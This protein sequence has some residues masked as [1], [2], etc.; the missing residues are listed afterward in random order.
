MNK[1]QELDELKVNIGE[2]LHHI[3]N[4]KEAKKYGYR[5]FKEYCEDKLNIS[6]REANKLINISDYYLNQVKIS[7]SD[8]LDY[9]WDKLVVMYPM[10]NEMSIS[11]VYK[12][13]EGL[14]SLSLAH[15]NAE[16]RAYKEEQKLKKTKLTDIINELFIDHLCSSLN[17]SKSEV[18]LMLARALYFVD[19]EKL[20]KMLDDGA[21]IV[22]GIASSYEE[23]KEYTKKI[24]S[25]LRNSID[26]KLIE[27]SKEH[28]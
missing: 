27:L 16:V 6:S 21:K 3:K 25:S 9:G 18:L 23:P 19:Q 15:V 17:G 14:E 5:N 2:Y 24:I 8:M 11:D 12:K 4:A 13:L 28:R 7:S 1:L 26:N 22:S 10:L 20:H